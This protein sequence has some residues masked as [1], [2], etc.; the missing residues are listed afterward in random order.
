MS[1]AVIRMTIDEAGH[2][3]EEERA[4]IIASYP[5]HERD[6]RARGIPQLGSG[7]IFPI[8]EDLV[9]VPQF[10]IPDYNV[11]IGGIDFGW[12]HPTAAVRLAWDRDDDVAYVT[13]AYKVREA[14]PIVH[15]AALRGW[16]DI[17]WS[18]PHDGLNDV[19]A[20]ENLAKQ[21]KKEGL[22]MLPEHARHA[23]G[24]N[25]VEAGL[26]DMLSRMQTGRLKVF[27]HLHEWFDEFG[28]YHRKD[29]KV[30][31]EFDDLMS[32]TRYG[33]MMLRHAR[34]MGQSRRRPRYPGPTEANRD[35][36]PLTY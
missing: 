3:T 1:R 36:N 26:M 30:V 11:Y 29:G 27:D 2:Y 7:R 28:M 33:L 23:D 18:W 13:A 8:S 15:A 14:T 22:A 21:Y 12:D 9:K 16:G 20:G 4:S 34:P 6:A 25:S 10:R 32:A 5:A 24:S 35:Y 17:V 31:K 19:A